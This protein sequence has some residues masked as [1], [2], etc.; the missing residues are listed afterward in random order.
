M[1]TAGKV[2]QVIREDM[3]IAQEI[4]DY[5]Q[6]VFSKRPAEMFFHAVAHELGY[7]PF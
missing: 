1:T 4:K 7:I 5:L 3:T 2:M 6:W